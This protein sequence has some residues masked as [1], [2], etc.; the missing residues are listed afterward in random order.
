M[1]RGPHPDS[2][3]AAS[4]FD[5]DGTSLTVARIDE[6]EVEPSKR[7]TVVFF[8]E[9]PK[10]LVLNEINLRTIARNLRSDEPADW[11]GQKVTPYSTTVTVNG[12]EVPCIRI[13]ILVSGHEPSARRRSV[14]KL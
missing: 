1:Q 5:S 10:G 9:V 7:K 13:K 12:N 4:D 3:L 8:N 11:V 14:K 6:A 2:W